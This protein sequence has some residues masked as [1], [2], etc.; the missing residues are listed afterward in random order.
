MHLPATA[1][2]RLENQEPRTSKAEVPRYSLSPDP[3]AGDIANPQSL[4]R[5]AYVRNNPTTLTDPDGLECQRADDGS[6]Y[7]DMSGGGCDLAGARSA[8]AAFASA[9][10]MSAARR[11]L[12]GGLNAIA[13]GC[14]GAYLLCLIPVR[15]SKPQA[16]QRGLRYLLQPRDQPDQQHRLQLRSRGQP[17]QRRYRHWLAY[18]PGSHTY[19]W[20]AEV[21]SADLRL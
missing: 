9:A 7:D 13:A 10:F 11:L 14:K 19:Q 17:D 1:D 20:D 16:Q 2:S 12:D 4:N 5:Y 3:L 6:F 18:L 8:D 15:C 21:S